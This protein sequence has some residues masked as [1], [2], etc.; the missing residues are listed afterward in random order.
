MPSL[1]CQFNLLT[2]SVQHS[3]THLLRSIDGG[4]A[5]YDAVAKDYDA[6]LL[7]FVRRSCPFNELSEHSRRLG[8]LPLRLGGLGLRS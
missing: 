2:K 3:L 7:K 4:S 5:L 6:A 8:F 1:Q